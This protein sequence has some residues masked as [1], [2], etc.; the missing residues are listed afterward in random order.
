MFDIVITAA[1]KPLFFTLDTPFRCL[2]HRQD[3]SFAMWHP[4]TKND[5][6]RVLVGGSVERLS[7][8]AG[9]EGKNVLYFG[10][11][12]HSD[13]VLPRKT[14]GW[15]TGAIIR[16]LESEFLVQQRDEYKQFLA[17]VFRLEA[18][19]NDVQSDTSVH[20]NDNYDSLQ[21]LLDALETARMELY[22]GADD[23]YNRHF[24]SIF[25]SLGDPS[26]YAL[27]L[28]RGCDIYTTR[29]ENF[30][31]YLPGHRFYPSHT[32]HL[33]HEKLYPT[34]SINQQVEE[35]LQKE[36]KAAKL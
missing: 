7:Q 18:L 36:G 13:L 14:R 9:W 22:A 1:N 34:S 24:G 31:Y 32:D 28:F 11:H 30:S 19:L 12:L 5:L 21:T 10:D 6:G 23:L 3:T 16:E 20:I 26:A 15:Y 2:N 29:I 35:T 27:A 4:V 25:R 33:P 8:L 17:T